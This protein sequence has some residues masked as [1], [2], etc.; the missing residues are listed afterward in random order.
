MTESEENPEK[1]SPTRQQAVDA[2]KKFVERGVASP[3][4]LDVNDPEV[5][6][7]NK[8]LDAWSV[9]AEQRAKQSPSPSA[10]QE[11]NLSRST[12]HTDA[13]FK[14][15]DYLDEV[16]NDW[17]VQD[18]Q[19]AQDAGFSELAQKIQSKRDELDTILENLD[20]AVFWRW[21]D[22]LLAMTDDLRR[23]GVS[24]KEVSAK[25]DE[26][27]DS[28]IEESRLYAQDVRIK[29]RLAYI[30]SIAGGLQQLDNVEIDGELNHFVYF[31]HSPESGDGI[32][33][34]LGLVIYPR[35]DDKRIE[36][37]GLRT[38]VYVVPI[39]GVEHIGYAQ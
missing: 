10:M 11:F 17:L 28:V 25:V 3:D 33:K 18:L 5:I 2:F 22:H 38:A 1:P 27:L 16:A 9:V 13:G 4:D 21:Q 34:E 29:V 14:D 32:T 31:V 24:D 30:D 8:V 19:A 35:S 7:A 20:I 6:E 15:P 37:L 12:V 26:Y 36:K 39:S 23:Q